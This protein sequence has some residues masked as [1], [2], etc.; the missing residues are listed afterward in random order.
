[1]HHVQHACAL[2]WHVLDADNAQREGTF[3]DS[4]KIKLQVTC[5]LFFNLPNSMWLHSLC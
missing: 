2:Q 1:M 5:G 3:N 4:H